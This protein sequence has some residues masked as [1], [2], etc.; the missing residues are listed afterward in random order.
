MSPARSGK[1][2]SDEH[3][4]TCFYLEHFPGLVAYLVYQGASAHIATD[5]AQDAMATTFRRWPEITFPKAYVFRV[6]DR[7][8]RRHTSRQPEM[9][10]A[11]VPEPTAV[12]PHPEMAEAWLQEQQIV[13]VLQELPSRQRQVLALTI[14]GW[15]QAEIAEMLCITR[16]AVRASLK[17][18]RSSADQH[19]RRIVEE[20]P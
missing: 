12:L 16:E 7:A 6:A 19:R 5:I 14:D 17:K 20:A 3:D 4:F 15:A 10:V 11:E 8:F 1:I 18:A 9:P 2:L 13:L